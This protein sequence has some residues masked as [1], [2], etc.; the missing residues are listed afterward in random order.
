MSSIFVTDA[1][2]FTAIARLKQR[3]SVGKDRV[4]ADIWKSFTAEQIEK[5]RTTIQR[6][7]NCEDEPDD[8]ASTWLR[9]L[10]NAI[11]KDGSSVNT[12]ELRRW[13]SVSC[14]ILQIVDYALYTVC[15][16]AEKQLPKQIVR[17]REGYDTGL[18]TES[19]RILLQKTHVLKTN[20]V[21][22]SADIHHAFDECDVVQPDEWL[23]N[24]GIDPR[25]RLCILYVRRAM[26]AQATYMSE[27][28]NEVAFLK[29]LRQGR[30]K[31]GAEFNYSIAPIVR[32]FQGVCER[33]K[34][35]L[36]LDGICVAQLWLTDNVFIVSK[37]ISEAVHMLEHL[38]IMLCSATN[39]RF[40]ISS[41]ELLPNQ[42]VYESEPAERTQYKV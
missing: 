34:W 42:H 3:V 12:M 5:L 41:F 11:S 15:E 36:L 1:A 40:K 13:I 39:M 20:M 17:Y 33:Y 8:G 19:F 28:S 27:E 38:A 21:I 32:D 10:A 2:V 35:G 7:V 24:V 14:H 6:L 30:S 4:S 26:R 25:V 31:S 16:R 18:V 37:S 22:R 9:I 23:G 29:A